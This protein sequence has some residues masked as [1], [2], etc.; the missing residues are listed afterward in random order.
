MKISVVIATYN[1]H[2]YLD[3]QLQ[4]VLNQ[5]LKPDEVIVCDDMSTD[6]TVNIL[7]EYQQRGELK[8]SINPTNLGVIENFKRGVAMARPGN[9]ISLC[10]QDDEWMPDKLERS[11]ALLNTFDDPDVPCM[12]YT[13]LRLVDRDMNVI[14]P[15]LWNE[16]G[17]QERYHHNLQNL[18]FNQF[19]NGCSTLLNPA[20]RNLVQTIPNNVKFYHDD[21]IAVAAFALGKAKSINEATV[22]YR[23]H[24]SN[25]TV[26]A[27]LKPR[28]RYRS[29]F[30]QL[31]R[32]ISGTD[33]FLLIRFELARM[34]YSR[35]SDQMTDDVKQYFEYF[36]SLEKKSYFKKKLAFR[37]VI[38]AN[39]NDKK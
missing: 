12:V 35:F 5:T 1:G 2:K 38:N 13:D 19:V 39:L 7:E 29:L 24:G 23:A 14:N 28:N 18:L 33:N 34:F 22:N 6:A 30:E 17:Q 25:V 31:T 21:W 8:Y 37:S 15:S 10:D 36:M 32:V 27:N 26:T 4:S 3:Q 9:Y 20:L 16:V 11:A